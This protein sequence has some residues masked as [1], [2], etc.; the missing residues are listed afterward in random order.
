MSS[1]DTT[2]PDPAGSDPEP[3]VPAAAGFHLDRETQLTPL[4]DGRFAVDVS[5]RWNIGD[6]PNG[7]YLTAMALQGLRSLDLHQDPMSVTTHYLRPGSGGRPGEIHTS[8]VRSGRA[9]TTG[10]ATLVQDGTQRLAV[11][12]AMGDLG[13][14]SGDGHGLTIPPPDMPPVEECVERDLLEQGVK[15]FISSR[16]DL[17][18]HPE[19]SVAGGSKRAETLGWI[20]FVDGRPPDTMAAVLFSD[21]FAPSIFALLGRVGWVPTIELTVHVRARP[22]PGWMLGRFV[23]EDLRDGRMVED[24][25]LW[26]SEGT[27]IARSR[28]LAMLLPDAGA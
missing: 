22:S 21:A 4:G 18:V 17:R 20:R 15:L 19:M 26:D 13:A 9:V 10:H 6:N 11:V 16:V 25:C 8:L 27:L 14:V 7:G 24:G 12:A 1:P 2:V 3:P 5:D 28:Q 23:T